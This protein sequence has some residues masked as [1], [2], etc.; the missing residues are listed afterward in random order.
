M[1]VAQK[2]YTHEY[3]NTLTQVFVFTDVVCLEDWTQHFADNSQCYLTM[4]TLP[5]K[6]Y[7]LL[8]LI[9]ITVNNC[10]YSI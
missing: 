10:T 9:T 3:N 5:F 6:I 8:I 4:K 7:A 1:K 2:M